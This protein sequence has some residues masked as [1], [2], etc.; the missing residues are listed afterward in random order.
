[1]KRHQA[2]SR[3]HGFTLIEMLVVLALMAILMTFAVPSL[4]TTLR[5]AKILEVARETKTLLVWA[6][7]EAIKH[8]ACTTLVRILPAA[9]TNPQRL[10]GI[11]DCNGD[12][13]QDASISPLV[14]T[15][16]ARV[17]FLAP[18]DLA[19]AASVDRFSP[20]PGP[21]PFGNV[22]LFRV[23]GSGS[24]SVDNPGAFRFGDQAGNFLEV[25]ITSVAG[26][27]PEIRKCRRCTDA[28]DD[29][30]WYANVKD[31]TWK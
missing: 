4:L 20:D 11:V 2:A 6:R 7:L 18:P 9:G 12:G 24:S 14:V 29:D 3:Q 19:G 22:A 5:Q 16:P 27:S 25:R 26:T 8:S 23:R 10:E 13:V 1:M 31:W 28:A 15:L 17:S 21:S 30:D